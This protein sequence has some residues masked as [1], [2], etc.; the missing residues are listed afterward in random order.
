MPAVKY[1][2]GAAAALADVRRAV[3]HVADGPGGAS[4]AHVVLLEAHTRWRAQ[5]QTMVHRGPDWAGYL[6]GGVDA[7]QQMLDDDG[8][9]DEPDA[10]N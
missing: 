4:T 1:C 6:A 5:S 7:L 8:G 3:E 9:F 10:Q 2:E